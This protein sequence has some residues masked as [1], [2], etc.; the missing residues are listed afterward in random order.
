MKKTIKFFM[1]FAVATALSFSATS[2][3]DDEE[4]IVTEGDK[5]ELNALIAECDVLLLDAVE[6]TTPGTYQE[7]SIAVFQASVDNAKVVSALEVGAYQE[8]IDAEYENL[9]A[10]KV[11]FEASYIP[12]EDIP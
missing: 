6:G 4:I 10:A 12:V 7:G 1:L 11:T 2:C 5:T 8:L 3:S 9:S